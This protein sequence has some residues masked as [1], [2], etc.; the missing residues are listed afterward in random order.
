MSEIYLVL[1][2]GGTAGLVAS[3]I[4]VVILY[5]NRLRTHLTL[6]ER[7]E[8]ERTALQDDLSE[9]DKEELA[10]TGAGEELMRLSQASIQQFGYAR[11]NLSTSLKRHNYDLLKQID[12]HRKRLAQSEERLAAM[13]ALRQESENVIENLKSDNEKLRLANSFRESASPTNSS[14][15]EQDLRLTLEEVARLK[16]Q[17]AEANMRLIEAEAE[18]IKVFTQELR[19]TLSSTLQHVALLL[20]ES[21]GNLNAMQRNFL[22]TIR[23]STARLNGLIEDF[24][25]VTTLKAD[26]GALAHDLVDLNQIIQEAI[27]D[28]SSQIRAKRITLNLDLPENLAPIY[29]DHEA[30]GQI[31]IRLLSNAGAASPVQ[32]TVH[33]RV[34][35]ETEDGKDYLLIQVSD[36]GGGIPPEDLRRVFIPL[37]RAVDVPARGV[38]DTGMGLFVAKTLTETQNG[39][40]W[41]DTRLGVGSTYSVLIP[42]AS[43]FFTH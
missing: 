42:I 5:R 26:A 20:D 36:T 41:V 13:T 8:E 32:G 15:I 17:L 10:E 16:N 6:R 11:E 43:P 35:I 2:V 18:G 31:L 3:F 19:Q 29:V 14:Q 30:L 34:Q 27:R 39:R 28:T 37:Y 21:T 40:I 33:L 12:E 22:E 25:Q 38:G 24:I 4:G 7:V 23:G 9:I 1:L